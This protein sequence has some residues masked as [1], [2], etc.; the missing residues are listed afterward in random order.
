VPLRHER[1]GDR[2]AKDCGGGDGSHYK[3]RQA[4]ANRYE[5]HEE[6]N[7][8]NSGP[9]HKIPDRELEQQVTREKKG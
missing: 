3:V 5:N 1:I 7:R 2:H 8:H 6:S 9:R 4:D